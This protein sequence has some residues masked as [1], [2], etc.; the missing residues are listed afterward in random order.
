MFKP[1]HLTD[2]AANAIAGAIDER[3]YFIQ[4]KRAGSPIQRPSTF[5]TT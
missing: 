4:S 5:S 2:E 1:N 3:V